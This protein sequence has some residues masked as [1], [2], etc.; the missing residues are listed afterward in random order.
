MTKFNKATNT[1]LDNADSKRR[2]LLDKDLLLQSMFR[3]NTLL[4]S[5]SRTEIILKKILDEVVEVINFDRGIIRLFDETKQFLVA[6]VVKNYTSEETKIAFDMAL[7]IN[8]DDCI[9]VKATKTGNPIAINDVNE[10]A[11]N[12]TELDKRLTKI[13]NRGSII[14]APL[15]I[16]HEVIGVITAWRRE[17]TNFFAEEID[18]FLTFATQVSIVI[19][20]ARLLETNS[21]KIRK[22]LLLQMAVSE[23]NGSQNKKGTIKEITNRTAK[24]ITG[25]D[26]AMIYLWDIQRNRVE[27]DDT[28]LK[29]ATNTNI[30][31]KK[32]QQMIEKAKLLNRTMAIAKSSNLSLFTDFSAEML[33]PLNYTDRYSGFLYVSKAKGEYTE[34]DINLLEI[35]VKNATTA[36]DNIIMQK[37]LFK[38]ATTLKDEVA[39]LKR[40]E[41]ML[42]GFHNIIGNSN[43]ISAIFRLIE[44]IA[45]HNTNVLITGESGTG[46]ELVSRAIHRQSPRAEKKFV[47]ISC[48]AIP[49]SLLESELF[50]YEAGAFTDAKKRKIGLLEHANGGTLL[51]DE[52]GEMDMLLQAKFLRMLEDGFIRRVGGVEKVPL[53]IR[54]I[55]ATN[56]DLNKMIDDG[57]FREDLFYRINVVP[58]KLPPLRERGKDIMLLAE[59][60]LSEFN[61]KFHRNIKGVSD[62]ATM[63]LLNYHWPGNIR[64]LRNVVERAIILKGSDGNT[65]CVADLPQEVGFAGSA[66]QSFA[67]SQQHEND[68]VGSIDFNSTIEKI[69]IKAKDK[70]IEDALTVSNGNKTRAAKLLGISRYQ[71]IREQKKICNHRQKKQAK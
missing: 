41:D 34:D 48:S 20:N 7:D 3:I 16:E 40:R 28:L 42:L 59:H 61:K 5:P 53:D 18:M 12:I 10:E 14:C 22:L 6:K 49:S 2:F 51:L 64:E 54:F 1:N 26:I 15:K 43:E 25:A 35:L 31:T 9:P 29:N 69:A 62:D 67:I 52:I 33:V 8:R 65:I 17:E 37:L 4:V 57:A 66:N 39:T 56:R 45:I 70:M 23:M 11:I 60:F 44:N 58:I 19:K 21:E 30:D 38:E 36:H 46:K 47:E 27:V 50:G 32:W 71:I 24:L 63:V 55:F 13:Q 68:I